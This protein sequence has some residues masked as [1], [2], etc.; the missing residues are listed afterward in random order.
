MTGAILARHAA[1]GAGTTGGQAEQATLAA[2]LRCCVREVAGPRG[3]VWPAGRYLTL[4]LAGEL[5]RVPVSGGLALRLDGPAERLERGRWLA[6]TADRL[7]RLAEAELAGS[8]AGRN[9][10]FAGQVARSRSAIAQLLGARAAA[11]PPDDPWLASEQ[12]LVHGHPF[13]PAPKARGGDGWLR[14]APEAHAAFPLRLLAVRDDV[15]AAGGDTGAIDRLG[16]AP[17]GHTLLPAHPWQLELL[18]AELAAPLAD[19]RLA[20][21]GEVPGPAVPTSSVRTVYAPGAG[22]CLKFSL[23]VRITNCVRK[24]SWY[25][26]AGAVELTARLA[27]LF[28]ALADRFPGTR[29]LPEPGY[30]SAALGTRLV[31]GLGVIVR[32]APWAVTGPGV[33]PVLAGALAALDGGRWSGAVPDAVVA[34]VRRDPVRWWTAYVDRVAPPVLDAYFRHGVVLECH[35]QNVLV[36]LDAGGLPVEAVF[37]DLEGAKLVAGRHEVSALPGPVAAALTYDA[38]RGW[39]RV[40]YCLLVNHLAE[41]AATVARLA[42]PAGADRPGRSGPSS[43]GRAGAGHPATDGLLAELWARARDRLDRHAADHGRPPALA[44]LLAGVPLPAKANLA[45]RWARA[46]DRDAGYVPVANPLSAAHPGAHP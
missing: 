18:A 40:V 11:R 44:D 31:E 30:R 5:L 28:A 17:P 12:A 25:E 27:P 35:L 24:N 45:T 46:A 37:R 26:L 3:Q 33:T 42:G 34:A 20:D 39:H 16:T 22:A 8:G 21:L 43:A 7:V 38:A 14:Y 9:D 19:G 1:G 15:R 10:E 2:L 29:W 4:R 13:H 36:G 32:A 41:I 6:L 23:D